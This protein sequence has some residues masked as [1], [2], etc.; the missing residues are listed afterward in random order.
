MTVY[1]RLPNGSEDKY[2]PVIGVE[3]E[4]DQ[5]YMTAMFVNPTLSEDA[6][7]GLTITG[8]QGQVLGRYPQNSWVSWRSDQ[9]GC[10]RKKRNT[11]DD[12][13]PE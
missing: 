7:G 3:K 9:A 10:E 11:S 6:K 4:Y 2:V 12:S 13:Y 5:L 1:V 8:H